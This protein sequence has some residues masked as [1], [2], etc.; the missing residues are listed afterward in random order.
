MAQKTTT[1]RDVAEKAGVSVSTVSHVLN[2][3]DQH[4]GATVRQ[5]VLGIVQELGY[6]PNAIARSMVKRKTAT[7][8]LIITEVDNPL[9]VP[10]VESANAVLRAAGHHILLASAPDL[11]SEKKAIETLRAQQVDGIIFMAIS[12]G[13]PNDHLLHLKEDGV[14]L[15]VINRSMGDSGIHQILLDDRGAGFSATQHLLQF[16]HTR[17]GTICGPIYHDP[18]RR[19]A[20]ERHRGWQ[21]ALQQAGL[22]LQQ[23]WIVEG[24]YTYEGGYQAAQTIIAQELERP[25]LRPTAL[26]IANEMM[27]VGAL[28]AFQQAG[29]RIPQDVAIVTIGDPPFLAYTMPALTTLA[30]PVAEAGHLAA[31]MLLD[32]FKEGKPAPFHPIT[33]NFHLVVRES[34]L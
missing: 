25:H 4:V 24:G 10:V 28:K 29:I 31:T 30:S 14:P 11:K 18:P 17:V 23:Q 3:N 7:I 13:Y 26:F 34:C 6:R 1:I 20:V 2:G 27:A 22:S 5:R 15:V 16:G 19:S 21:E 32:W 9:F 33:L 8:G 12:L